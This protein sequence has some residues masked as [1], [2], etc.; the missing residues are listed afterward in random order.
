[1]AYQKK[2]NFILAYKPDVLI[3]SECEHP[4]KLLFPTDT[5][6]PEDVLWF[7]E[8]PHKG[9]GIFS[10]SHY[11]FQV[12]DTHNVCF[13]KIIPILVTGGENDFNL[14]AIW[15]NNPTDPDGQYVEH[16]WKALHYDDKLLI[17]N[18]AVLIGDFNS[19]TIWDRKRRESNHSDVV[20]LLAVKKIFITYHLHHKQ[21]QGTEEH[22]TLY[23]YRHKDRA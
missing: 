17:D 21:S 13:R 8:N 20:K 9:L 6:R 5:P 16:I 15:A 3:V 23:L 12:L 2:A 7:G 10:Y 22:P 11:R 18:Q 19:N 1:M 4:D 14:F